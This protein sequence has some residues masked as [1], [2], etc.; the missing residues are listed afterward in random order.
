MRFSPEEED[1]DFYSL[2]PVM[3]EDIR[4]QL[5]AKL[6]QIIRGYKEVEQSTLNVMA[7]MEG[8]TPDECKDNLIVAEIESL[9]LLVLTK[10]QSDKTYRNTIY[11]KYDIPED[12]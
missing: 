4:N 3:T 10:F 11:R 6:Y 2:I 8:I 1:A 7:A 12:V 9:Y 5:R